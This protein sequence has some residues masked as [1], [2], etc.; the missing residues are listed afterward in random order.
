MVGVWALATNPWG[1]VAALV[2]FLLH[3]AVICRAITR[4]ARSPASR[5]AWVAVILFLPIIGILAYL[6][7]GETSIG[8]DRLR[9]M[10]DAEREIQRPDGTP[11][12][13]AQLTP[14]T[15]SL[16]DMTASISGF[17]AVTGNRITLA[18]DSDAA[19]GDLVADIDAATR[20]VHLS[21]YIWLDDHN[22]G[23]VADAVS[24]AA[25]RGVTC[26]I[27]VDALGSRDF[28]K[29]ARWAQMRDA[30]AHCTV[31]LDDIPRLG[32]LAIGRPDL[33][34]HRKIAVI[35][36]TIA[37]CGSQN[38]ADPA[39]LPG[40]KYAPWVDVF[41]R[42]E[43]PVVAQEQWL[44]LTIWQAESGERIAADAVSSITSTHD[45]GG[46]G[47]MFGTGPASRENAMT[48][49]FVACIAAAEENLVITTPY[50][51]PDA[52]LLAAICAAPRR[53]VKTILIVP[54]RNN[55]W[56]VAQAAYAT[57][58]AMLDAGVELYEYPLGLL[59][60]K[61]LTADGSI[62]LVGS[63]NM[64]RRSLQLNFENNLLVTDAGTATLTR[65]R[66]QQYLDA[67]HRVDPA[68]V[69][70]WSFGRRLVQNTVSML[71]PL[72]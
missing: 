56:L 57:Y 28:V 26:R 6:F 24:A 8:R 42:C 19:I 55:S 67:S 37:Y 62:A 58:G 32:N 30:G 40:K 72:L 12:A 60:S 9:R 54:E 20:T 64:D 5:I 2:I 52:A 68:S 3:V 70:S 29:G 33:R 50:F 10:H 39:F 46:L 27:M 63:A 71:A 7:L 53:G 34:N 49:A 14:H 17:P 15:R 47:A 18:A 13:P 43:G 44:F 22:G 11:Y 41:F 36:D 48:D 35:D 66:Q 59:H 31:A 23:R 38:C 69:A 4:P 45:E 16:F 61:T 51:V 1:F 21:F 65:T 25:R